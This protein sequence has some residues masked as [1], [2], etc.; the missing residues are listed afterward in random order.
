M[1]TYLWTYNYETPV[2]LLIYASYADFRLYVND[3][4]ASQDLHLIQ[5]VLKL[6]WLF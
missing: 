4:D 2:H 5:S 3:L 6:A 1:S